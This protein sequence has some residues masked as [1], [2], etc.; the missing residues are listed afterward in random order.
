[1][2][3][4]K[5][6]L[7]I[8]ISLPTF[9]IILLV[10]EIALRIWWGDRPSCIPGATSNAW[11]KKYVHGNALSFRGPLP[12]YDKP[13]GT[14]RI[15]AIGDSITF[16]KGIEKE[17][18]RF[19]EQLAA[20]I[21][22]SFKIHAEAINMGFPT[23]NTIDEYFTLRNKG[24]LFHPDLVVLG[25]CYNDPETHEQGE[26]AVKS[27]EIPVYFR[28][29]LAKS[30]LASFLIYSIKQKELDQCVNNYYH[31]INA[32]DAPNILGF[33]K[34]LKGIAN[35]SHE[36][37]ADF[38]VVVFPILFKL[39]KEP[40]EFQDAENFILNELK[41]LDILYA[42]ILPLL[43]GGDERKY[44]VSQFDSHPNEGVHALAARELFKI[45][46]PLAKQRVS[47]DKK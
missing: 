35:L 38:A 20:M 43:K 31:L 2:K 14:F 29:L 6:K 39:D 44:W 30:Y 41:S 7:L 9:V 22:N 16:G 17:E 27:I 11:F 1:M 21:S 19:P 33:R 42:D 24:L 10:A 13:Q 34:A 5:I 46:A 40:Y 4:T 28:F 25:Y 3:Y 32:P 8:I 45:V 37:N 18:D 15:V 36:A 12:S 47:S 26:E 23:R